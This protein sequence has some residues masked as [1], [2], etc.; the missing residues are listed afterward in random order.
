CHLSSIALAM[1]SV[2]KN[3]EFVTRALLKGLFEPILSNEI[4][5][6]SAKPVAVERGITIE[7]SKVVLE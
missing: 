6:V 7:E 3:T 5:L 1:G 4:N 2:T